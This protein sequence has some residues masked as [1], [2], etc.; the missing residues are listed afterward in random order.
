MIIFSLIS[1]LLLIAA[2]ILLLGLTPERITDDIM[3][4]V[5]PKQTLRDK[6]KIAQGKKKSRKIAIE[7]AHIKDALTATGK[8]GQFT[9]VCALSLGL[10]ICGGLFAVLLGNLLLLPIFA[11]ALA[12]VP[13]LHARN[14][15]DYYDRHIAEELE[16][17]LSVVSTAYVRS[18][19]IVMAVNEN[20]SYLKPP[21]RDIFKAFLGEVTVINADIKAA[22]VSLKHKVDNEIWA[23]WCDTLIRCQD[24]RTLKSTLLP[25]V[26]KL[27]DIRIVNNELKTI[28]YDP[29]KEYWVMV[30]LV[31]GN[32]PLLYILSYDWF[33][34][35]MYSTPGKIALAVCGAAVLI[36]ARLMFKYTRPIEYK[37]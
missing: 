12:F 35:L 32:L 25:V 16:T 7:L 24:D 34:T 8:G 27:T 11:V 26:N 28:L 1:S 30:A 31:I 33:L 15:I 19:D 10:L 2:I 6:A 13:F 3:R 37:R 14:T 17:A 18:D 36:T 29:K 20:I 4:I 9:V 5:S 22:L 21:V 23:E